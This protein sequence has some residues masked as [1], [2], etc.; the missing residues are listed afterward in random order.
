M[1]RFAVIGL[2]R[3]GM[4]LAVSLADAGAEV[5]AIDRSRELVEQV[6]DRVA[7]AVCLDA[8]D[9]EALRAQGID[10]VDVAIVGIGTNF[11][12]SVLSTVI[13]KQIGVPRVISRATTTV[14]GHVL[15]RVGANDIVNPERESADRWRSRLLAPAV[16]ER[17]VL[18]E[19]YS[20]VQVQAPAS[21]HDRSLADLAVNTR[22]RVLVVAIR[23][24]VQEEE[25]G[26]QVGSREVVITAPGPDS[27]V[28]PDD[29]L[30]LIGSDQAIEGFPT[31]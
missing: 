8:T 11:E 6:K 19:G 28:R 23:R 4:R 17:T 29:V 31:G 22:Y 1:E 10:K 3:F 26:G 2:G 5:I 13:L 9:E 7:L 12:E 30:V 14:R 25:G 21:F 24:T 27:V 16:L 20:L 15:A 18:A